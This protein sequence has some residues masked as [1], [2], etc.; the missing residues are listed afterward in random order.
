MTAPLRSDIRGIGTGVKIEEDI[1]P[2][3]VGKGEVLTHGEDILILAIGSSVSEALDAHSQLTE[4]GISATVVNCR[5]VKPLDSDLICSLARKIPRIITVEENVRDG[6][7]GSAVLECL[8]DKG[9]TNFQLERIG[10]PDTFVEH[11][12]QKFLRSKYGIDAPAIA[13]AA[14]RQLRNEK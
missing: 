4:Q 11:G 12:P 6:G 7:F 8:C 5:F 10:I 3:P 9:V 1:V 13:D 2:V 14:R